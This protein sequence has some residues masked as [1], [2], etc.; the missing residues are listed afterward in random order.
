MAAAQNQPARPL[1][2]LVVEDEYFIAQELSLALEEMGTKVI[3]PV[4][5]LDEAMRMVAEHRLSGAILDVNLRGEMVFA[6]AD[7]LTSQNVPFVFATG[8]DAQ[9]IPAR[10]QDVPRWEKPFDARAL[11]AVLD[12]MATRGI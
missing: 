8:Y 4:G 7:E 2:V 1:Q 3:G 9:V 12:G 5:K 11:S 10:F 6:L